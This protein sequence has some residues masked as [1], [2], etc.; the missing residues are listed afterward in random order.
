MS[1]SPR[2]A[3][4]VMA[5]RLARRAPTEISIAAEIR[6]SLPALVKTLVRDFHARRVVL[7]GSVARGMARSDA[8]IDL[9]VEG[10]APAMYFRAL[11]VLAGIAGRSVDLIMIEEASPAVLGIIGEGEVLHDDQR[12]T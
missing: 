1:I 5:E 9:A 10:L 4:A 8:D 11:A 12:T 3:V 7:I 2:D 6:R